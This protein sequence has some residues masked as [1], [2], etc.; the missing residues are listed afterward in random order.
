MYNILVVDDE[1]IPAP[2]GDESIQV[3]LCKS[4][5]EALEFLKEWHEGGDLLDE[6]WLDYSL[7]GSDDILPVLRWLEAVAEEG[8]PF[9]VDLIYAHSSAIS[10]R[11]FVIDVLRPH[12]T[13]TSATLPQEAR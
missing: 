10:G 6:L 5:E 12:Y 1:R 7:A 4:S 13:V 9:N 8:R 2:G 3:T 11:S